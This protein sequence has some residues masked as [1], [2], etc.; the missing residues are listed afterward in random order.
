MHSR[1]Q[2]ECA[3]S[4]LHTHRQPC[5]RSHLCIHFHARAHHTCACLRKPIYAQVPTHTDMP[6]RSRAHTRLCM[7]SGMCARP[8]TPR[9]PCTT[10]A[11]TGGPL[12]GTVAGLKPGPRARRARTVRRRAAST[13]I[14]PRSRPWQSGGMK[15][16]MWNTPRFTFSSS[17]RRLSSSKGSAPCR[18]GTGSP[19][20]GGTGAG[21]GEKG[22][23][24]RRVGRGEKGR[25]G[26]QV[27]RGGREGAWQAVRGRARTRAELGAAG[28][29]QGQG[30]HH[31]QREQDH[32]AAPHV[33]LAAVVL[34]PLRRAARL[35][36]AGPGSP[37]GMRGPGAGS[38]REPGAGG[39]RGGGRKPSDRRGLGVVG[40]DDYLPGSPQG[41]HSGGT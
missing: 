20:G 39:P 21:R 37:R 35:A 22:R 32:P 34:L 28:A 12:P 19:R 25:G 9:A 14:M 13:S 2:P 40:H 27:G 18:P 41:R 10:L 8:C 36:G 15:C 3:H 7:H 1:A 31:Q 33:R 26:R 11:G 5:T 16:G 38:E 24:R 4:P 30:A 17:C 23:G 6:P 29:A